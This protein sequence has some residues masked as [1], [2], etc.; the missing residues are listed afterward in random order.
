MDT[1]QLRTEFELSEG[2]TLRAWEESDLLDAYDIVIQ[3]RAHLQTFM[4]WM[5]NEYS[6]E[7]SRKFLTNAIANRKEKK[8]LGLGIFRGDK[9]IGSIGFV[10]FDWEARKTEIGYWIAKV[11]EGKGIVTAATRRLIEYTFDELGFNRVEIRC[12]TE[13]ARSA[14]VPIRLGFRKEALLRQAE[15]IH[16]RLHDFFV[17]A[18]L[19]EDPRLW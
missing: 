1:E 8:N 6:M 10:Y 7:D 19:A 11:E 12:S 14:A 15:V 16:D 5:T 17:F 3:E 18:L 4:R 13:N 9:L 2:V